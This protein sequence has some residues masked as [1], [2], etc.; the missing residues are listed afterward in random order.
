MELCSSMS[1]SP[2]YLRQF[3]PFYASNPAPA[4]SQTTPSRK[5]SCSAI[6]ST[7]S[8]SCSDNRYH[9]DTTTD[10]FDPNM[11]PLDLRTR[12]Q[13]EDCQDLDESVSDGSVTHYF[14]FSTRC[15]SATTR[16]DS[17]AKLVSLNFCECFT[18]KHQVGDQFACYCNGSPVY[19]LRSKL[20][21]M[22]EEIREHMRNHHQSPSI[23]LSLDSSPPELVI[24]LPSSS[25]EMDLNSP[26]KEYL[27]EN[28]TTP[29]PVETLS[30]SQEA[31]HIYKFESG[32]NLESLGPFSSYRV[33]MTPIIS[34]IS[35]AVATED[36]DL[37]ED[38]VPKVHQ[39]T[40]G[41]QPT[42]ET[43]DMDE[44]Q[45][46]SI[47]PPAPGS[48]TTIISCVGDTSEPH[49]AHDYSA[50]I[51]ATQLTD[52]DI[53][54]SGDGA[55]ASTWFI[56]EKVDKSSSALRLK[57]CK[58]FVVDDSDQQNGKSLGNENTTGFH[59][60]K[61]EPTI[62]Q[63]CAKVKP[64]V[65]N[66]NTCRYPRNTRHQPTSL[67]LDTNSTQRFIEGRS[68][69]EASTIVSA[70]P[71]S[72]ANTMSSCVSYPATPDVSF[73]SSNAL[74]VSPTHH[75]ISDG[76][77]S[78]TPNVRG[79]VT[80]KDAYKFTKTSEETSLRR[81]MFKKKVAA[82]G[83]DSILNLGFTSELELNQKDFPPSGN[84]H[85]DEGVF[86]KPKT[87]WSKRKWFMKAFKQKLICQSN[88]SVISAMD[89]SAHQEVSCS[90]RVK[91][92]L[93][94]LTTTTGNRFQAPSRPTLRPLCGKTATTSTATVAFATLSETKQSQA[95]GQTA[96]P[97]IKEPGS[98]MFSSL[99]SFDTT[100]S[101]NHLVAPLD[102]SLSVTANESPELTHATKA[103]FNPHH[104]VPNTSTPVMLTESLSTSAQ[105]DMFKIPRI[106]IS[107][108]TP[109]RNHSRRPLSSLANPRHRGN[110][111]KPDRT[112]EASGVSTRTESSL[113]ES[114]VL[115][116]TTQQSFDIKMLK[117]SARAVAELLTAFIEDSS[118]TQF[119]AQYK[120]GLSKSMLVSLCEKCEIRVKQSKTDSSIFNL[121]KSRRSQAPTVEDVKQLV[122]R[123]R[124]TRNP[125]QLSSM[126]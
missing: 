76:R 123:A 71:P 41:V 115:S 77:I 21:P 112:R 44:T 8:A 25:S 69:C 2:A 50:D 119:G 79:P 48:E 118:I 5:M 121:V 3:G 37:K 107:P 62:N 7:E 22:T 27:R 39:E 72:A 9:V 82:Q 80:M 116:W 15:A 99:R 97:R 87:T 64:E 111:S 38:H 63:P 11:E 74:S 53:S 19:I 81:A 14:G 28:S 12:S 67:S 101:L 51:S 36:P 84:N 45:N 35:D 61:Y 91:A 52:D 96:Q 103:D 58:T 31:R 59:D 124:K 94:P 95:P 4:S 54:V 104:R 55:D 42:S 93:H 29:T 106:P 13:K 20:Q 40:S 109:T 78:S 70:S 1:Q 75:V 65:Q 89:N 108:R 90:E 114:N 88:V 43:S 100:P 92:A 49:D 66:V 34:Q 110:L 117:R 85:K 122:R 120:D 18:G 113:S 23:T 86:K 126:F 47:R 32:E 68:I 102:L 56:K 26:E 30:L 24:D 83:S 98:D 73:H 46:L 125:R 60:K 10:D 33:R 105:K 6:L 17:P 16:G 57:L